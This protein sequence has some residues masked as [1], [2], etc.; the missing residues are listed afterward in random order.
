MKK[1]TAP[2]WA[3]IALVIILGSFITYLLIHNHNE[4]QKDN[5]SST[6]TEQSISPAQ[7][8]G[9]SQHE[10]NH[11]ALP[12]LSTA[13]AADESEVKIVTT[14]GDI[15]IKL[16]NSIAPLAV[17]NFVTH[18]KDGYYN[19]TTFHRIIKDFMIQGGDPKGDGTGGNSIWYQKDTK[20]DP[21]TGFKNELSSSLYNIRG[22]LAMANT[23]QESSNGSQF[24][25]NQ[26]SQDQ[27]S[28][29]KK[30][31]YPTRIVKAYSHGGNPNLDG[32]YTVFGQVI[33][34]MDV[35][36]KIANQA[37]TTNDA[38]NEQSKPKHPVTV[39]QIEVIK[40]APVNI[41]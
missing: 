7:N 1:I 19:N 34:G 29:L 15:T 31:A 5:S 23:G 10:L 22:A 38:G 27:R 32:H 39:K 33:K 16:F 6:Q 36:D 28:S 3:F 20:I 30:T 40:E 13:V 18:A 35:V 11:V 4:A 37:V 21:G 14:K 25:I 12:Q 2:V 8:K 24:F 9:K 17:D 26:N 41:N